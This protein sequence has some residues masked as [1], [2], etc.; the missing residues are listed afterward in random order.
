MRKILAFLVVAVCLG[1]TGCAFYHGPLAP[2]PSVNDS[3]A[4]ELI[5]IR[6]WGLKAG[7]GSIH[8]NLNGVDVYA[9]ENGAYISLRVNAG[10]H[11]I[12]TWIVKGEKDRI[13]NKSNF[14]QLSLNAGDKHYLFV[15]TNH[16]P[17][18]VWTIV[19]KLSQQEGEELLKKST[20]TKADP[21]PPPARY[22][23]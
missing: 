22:S 17:W 15:R 10:N 5:I 16:N 2:L 1:I 13:E 20:P 11:S 19:K 6:D 21:G 8:I 12:M 9:L 7:A 14:I 4:A 3:D 23:Q 18:T